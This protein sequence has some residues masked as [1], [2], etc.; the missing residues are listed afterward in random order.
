MCDAFCARLVTLIHQCRCRL[1]SPV[2]RSGKAQEHHARSSQSR[3]RKK[4]L[5]RAQAKRQGSATE[6]PN[7]PCGEPTSVAGMQALGLAAVSGYPEIRNLEQ[8]CLELSNDCREGAPWAL[9]LRRKS[10]RN[11]VCG[12]PLQ[13]LRPIWKRKAGEPEA[14]FNVS[15]RLHP[16]R[17]IRRIEFLS[18]GRSLEGITWPAGLKTVVFGSKFQGHIAPDT[19]WPAS[20]LEISL[21]SA[22]FS[23]IN[24]MKWP[25][26]LRVLKF[27]QHHNIPVEEAKFP[28]GLQEL[29][30]GMDFNQ[31]IARVQWPSELRILNLGER[32][33]HPVVAVKWPAK[34][35]ELHFSVF[36]DQELGE[37]KLPEG[38]EVLTFGDEFQQSV[39][40]VK[41]P[42]ALHTVKFGVLYD[43]HLGDVVWP[44]SLK[45]L[46]VPDHD[47]GMVPEACE[48]KIVRDPFD[49]IV[50]LNADLDFGVLM[51]HVW[52]GGAPFDISFN[53]NFLPLGLHNLQH[54]M[55]DPEDERWGLVWDN[56]S[57][58]DFSDSE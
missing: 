27:G 40:G 5:A 49:E 13:M 56:A 51:H 35:K 2:V 14:P 11:D 25:P 8:T 30:F 46:T 54:Q 39:E 3:I 47:Y 4:K 33:D 12:V 22:T 58:G 43:E 15:S 24:K 29:T 19:K 9:V 55:A 7:S 44:K 28:D 20:L 42:P 34:L 32:F 52:L 50:A 48:V 6:A 1:P 21:G 38:L 36:F 26:S 17:V 23:S 45:H 53:P 37:T 16:R 57:H 41:W 31:P 10:K 18:R